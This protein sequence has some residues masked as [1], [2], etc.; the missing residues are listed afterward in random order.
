MKTALA[1]GITIS[2]QILEQK[3]LIVH[4]E[5][6][7]YVVMYGRSLTLECSFHTVIN[8]PPVRD[9]YWQYSNNGVI[10]TIEKDTYGISGSS[11]EV[12]SMTIWAVTTSESGT[13][14]CFAKTDNGTEQSR[15][16]NVTVIGGVFF[17][18]YFFLF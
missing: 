8:S 17:I 12:P 9:I 2:F 5:K 16:I 4:V 7:H 15:P 1:C 14:I 6:D 13:Y 10:T 18:D 3:D 11:I